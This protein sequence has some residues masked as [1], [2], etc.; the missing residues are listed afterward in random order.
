MHNYLILALL[1]LLTSCHGTV[2]LIQ[3]ITVVPGQTPALNAQVNFM[4]TGVGKCQELTI[5]WGDD[6][7]LDRRTNVDL[8]GE[9]VSHT[10]SGWPGGKTVTV[11]AVSGCGGSARTR[12][13]IEP[14]VVTIGW[15]RDPTR[16]VATCNPTPEKPDLPSMSL[17]HITSPPMPV[18][19]FSCQFNGCIYDADGRPGS[20]A[21]APFPFPGLRE[22]SLVLR[23][24]NQVFQGGKDAQFTVT[25]G[26]TLELCQNT[27]NPATVTG[28]WQVDIKVNELGK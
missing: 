28:G 14:S 24:G 7:A 13:S 10:Y 18:V 5:D 1:A 8:M 15:A 21:A 3:A 9:P 22:Y 11:Q 27:N 26:G 23:V 6:S 19:N 12:F 4:V 20:A 16:N 17:V 2:N 25:T